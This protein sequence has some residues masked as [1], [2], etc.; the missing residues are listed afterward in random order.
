MSELGERAKAPSA[1]E[2]VEHAR[3]TRFER[4][5]VVMKKAGL[6]F[7]PANIPLLDTLE[8]IRKCFT[9]LPSTVDFLAITDINQ[10][11]D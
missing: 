9:M 8:R 3:K 6:V 10:D 1:V 4:R 2:I 5:K 7:T 11:D